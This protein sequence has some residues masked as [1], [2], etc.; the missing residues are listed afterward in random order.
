[1]L[2]HVTD[3]LKI[4]L[5]QNRMRHLLWI[6]V[7]C[8]LFAAAAL[9]F[10]TL[11]GTQTDIEAII[12]TLKLPAMVSMFG[13]FTAEPPYTTANV[14]A[15]EMLVFMGMFVVFMNISLA[16]GNTR[17]Q[18]DSGLLEMVRSRSVARLSQVVATGVEIVLINA[19]MGML[20]YL[21]LLAA[22]LNGATNAG[23]ILMGCVL[24]AVGVMFGFIALVVAQIVNNARSGYFLSY[25]IFGVFYLMR[26]MTDIAN[27]KFTWLSPFGWLQKTK[28]YTAD[29]W[30]PVFL[31]LLLA[32]VMG[33]L[34]LQLV[35]NRD[36]GSGLIESRQ[37]RDKASRWLNSPLALVLRLERNS[38]LGWLVGGVVLGAAYGSIFNT[39]GDIIKTNPT[40]EALLGV[41]QVDAANQDLLLNFIGFVSVFY[42]ILAAISGA[43]IVFRLVKDEDKGYL[44]LI[45]ASATSRTSLIGSYLFVG[46]L[47]AVLVY[48]ATIS[49]TFFSGNATLEN[50]IPLSYFWQTVAGCLPEVL[51][52]LSIAFVIVGCL[53]KFKLIFWGYLGLSALIKLFGPLLNLADSLNNVS[54]FGW[55]GNVP[56][57]ELSLMPILLILVAVLGCLIFSLVGYNQR[58]KG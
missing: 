4:N 54:P 29:N 22:R 30:L 52:F 44:D 15:S 26:M 58:D 1:M 16:I 31:M 33:L 13:E 56:F 6:V 27:P 23:D 48:L 20:F 24:A 41:D 55:I 37:G 38:L 10:N 49:G 28:I 53:P 47:Q 50:K 17:A 3:L 45:A 39:V 32:A 2:N 34:A 18:E 14:F 5:K 21:S 7:L 12:A 8:G 40:Y 35:K 19:V 11:F 43:S 25:G 57:E 51:F 42:A 36:I 46:T 9:K